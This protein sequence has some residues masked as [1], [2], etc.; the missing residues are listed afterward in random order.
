M[1]SNLFLGYYLSR[2]RG[3]KAGRR[4]LSGSAFVLVERAPLCVLNRRTCLTRVF[5][6]GHFRPS[7]NSFFFQ[8]V[9]KCL[10][11]CVQIFCPPAHLHQATTY[12]Y[13]RLSS[14]YMWSCLC[15]GPLS[16]VFVLN[17]CAEYLFVLRPCL[18]LVSCPSCLVSSSVHC[19]PTATTA[20]ASV[21]H[22]L[23]LASP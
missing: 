4:W 14:F 22:T 2:K 1:V 19:L 15:I 21:R 10:A 11:I 6:P 8:F 20:S 9:H 3:R 18:L 7:K 16:C 12:P 23:T 5:P 17:P 13:H